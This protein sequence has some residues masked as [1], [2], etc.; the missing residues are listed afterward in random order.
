M[1]TILFS[2]NIIQRKQDY[3][4]TAELF[5]WAEELTLIEQNKQEP[6]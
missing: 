2:L 4:D 1:S 5:Q 3:L 6:W